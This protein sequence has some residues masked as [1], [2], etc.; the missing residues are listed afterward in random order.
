MKLADHWFY[1]PDSSQTAAVFTPEEAMHATKVLRLREG[2]DLQWLDGK[3][4]RYRGK[5]TDISKRSMSAEVVEIAQEAKPADTILAIGQL[6]D[7]ARME[8]LV[9][10]GTELGVTCFLLVGSARV[11][12]TRYKLAR[13]EAK[14]IAAMKQSQRSW[15]PELRET[16]FAEALTQTAS[17]PYRYI[18]HCYEDLLRVEGT[19]GVP[20]DEGMAIFI[21]PEGDFTIAEVEEALAATCTPLSLGSARLRSETAALAA[22]LKLRSLV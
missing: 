3:G 6:H 19:S 15:L 10:K 4:G 14:C 5:L 16:G 8:W 9:E 20:A 1:A 13:L 17:T 11:E 18:A 22:I 21:G 2:D 12:R 7:A